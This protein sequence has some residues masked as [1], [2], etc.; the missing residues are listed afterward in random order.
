MEDAVSF[1]GKTIKEKNNKIETT[2]GRL[3]Q[4]SETVEK[5]EY[6]EKHETIKSIEGSTKKIIHQRKFKKFSNLVNPQSRYVK[7]SSYLLQFLCD[8]PSNLKSPIFI[9]S[10]S[11]VFFYS[12]SCQGDYHCT[13]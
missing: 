8:V 13:W 9:R 10:G 1:C 2:K 11:L 7:I 4:Q 6:K 3:K 12:L 5:S